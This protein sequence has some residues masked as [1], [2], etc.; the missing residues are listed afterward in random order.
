MM[1]SYVRWEYE[2]P[3]PSDR[4]IMRSDEY[5]LLLAEI[6]DS[7]RKCETVR[8]VLVVDGYL[9]DNLELVIHL[10]SK[11]IG[12][13]SPARNPLVA[14]AITL[15][16]ALSDFSTPHQQLRQLW[17]STRSAIPNAAA[18]TR[19]FD[20]LID[21]YND[22]ESEYI[23]CGVVDLNITHTRRQ[24][25]WGGKSRLV[26]RLEH[27]KRLF[28]LEITSGTD[29]TIFRDKI[30]QMVEVLKHLEKR[31]THDARDVFVSASAYSFCCAEL[32]LDR[33]HPSASV[34]M[35]N[36]ATEFLLT[37]VAVDVGVVHLAADRAYMS[38][39][40]D[41]GVVSVIRELQNA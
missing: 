13:G 19:I 17:E 28:T 8:E 24:A 23:A 6:A 26:K 1:A 3:P 31:E 10:K 2:F 15:C 37:A 32:L 41:I 12:S 4:L 7:D 36:R 9:I 39:G 35:L 18:F 27:W 38:S 25:W 20:L 40:N 16:A 21:L 29:F 30:E 14:A 22:I 11:E 33:G 5:E 34:M